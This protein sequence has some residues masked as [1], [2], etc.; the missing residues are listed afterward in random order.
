MP[1]FELARQ[2]GMRIVAGTDPLPLKGEEARVGSYGFR[3]RVGGVETKGMLGAFKHALEN[4]SVPVEI[5]GTRVSSRQ[6]LSNQLRL[7]LQR[8]A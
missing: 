3:I 5:V 4:P 2:Q 6:F 8:S 1:Q 7:R